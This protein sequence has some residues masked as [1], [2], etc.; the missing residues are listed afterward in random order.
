VAIT[1]PL[2][3]ERYGFRRSGRVE[4]HDDGLNPRPALDL[5]D[6]TTSGGVDAFDGPVRRQASRF[7][8]G[9]N[10]EFDGAG[11]TMSA[12]L[13][14][15]AAALHVAEEMQ[16]DGPYASF[17]V[18]RTNSAAQLA[19][20]GVAVAG[21]NALKRRAQLRIVVDRLR[22]QI[23]LAAEPTIWALSECGFAASVARACCLA[24]ATAFRCAC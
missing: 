3:D 20:V 15:M 10:D 6:R 2:I 21:L 16:I 9:C 12:K 22:E 1:F 11:K 13:A 17:S 23:H 8:T 5:W 19:E 4:A 14:G 18:K 7:T 24:S